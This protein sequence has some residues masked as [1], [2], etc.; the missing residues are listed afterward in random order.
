MKIAWE[1]NHVSG[2]FV[3]SGMSLSVSSQSYQGALPSTG[4]D[5]VLFKQRLATSLSWSLR[6]SW[7]LGVWGEKEKKKRLTS[8][9]DADR[10]RVLG[11]HPWWFCWKDMTYVVLILWSARNG[12]ENDQW[13]LYRTEDS[14]ASGS[15][16]VGEGFRCWSDWWRVNWLICYHSL[17]HFTPSTGEYG[18]PVW[19][20]HMLS[21]N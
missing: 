3:L 17:T 15:E 18:V 4:W 21:N 10:L 19:V 14:A 6:I 13:R 7:E 5:R 20:L 16:L 9:P 8:E 11:C 1:E 2:A 12:L